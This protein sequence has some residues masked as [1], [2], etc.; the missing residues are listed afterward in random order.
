VAPIEL[1]DEEKE[2][3]SE[4]MINYLTVTE[5]EKAKMPEAMI[6]RAEVQ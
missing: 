2:T 1:T 6:S 4:A 5:E 3:M